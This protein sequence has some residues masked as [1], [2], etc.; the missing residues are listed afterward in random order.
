MKLENKLRTRKNQ[1][2]EAL[3]ILGL[4]RR[5]GAVAPG[6]AA[7]RRSISQGEARL[8]LMAEDAS[9][10]QLDKIRRTIRKRIIPQVLLGDRTTL[11]AAIGRAPIT[12]VAVT[13]ASLAGRLLESIDGEIMVDEGRD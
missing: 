13:D 11:G 10:T 8:V 7:T 6:T 5:A 4:A 3:Q 2:T 12:A 9:L 1:M